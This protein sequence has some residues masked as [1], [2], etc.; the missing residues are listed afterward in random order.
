M[1]AERVSMSVR[2]FNR[3]FTGDVGTTP[4]KYVLHLRVEAPRRSLE[5]SSHDLKQ[6]STAVGFGSVDSM[7]R[8]FA[9]VLGKPPWLVRAELA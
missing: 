8:A 7:R 6:I 1:L 4:A 3:V 9:R 5:S 2:N